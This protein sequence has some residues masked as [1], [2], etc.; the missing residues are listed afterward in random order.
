LN[1]YTETGYENH[2]LPESSPFAD[3]KEARKYAGPLPHTFIYNNSKKEVLIIEGVRHNWKP[4]PVKVID[5]TIPFLSD[6]G[7]KD[8]ILA[9]AFIIRN[10][11]YQWKKGRIEKWKG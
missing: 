5:Y 11:P 4:N 6:L 7:L 1:I 8:V 9:S 2:A 10:V 3:W